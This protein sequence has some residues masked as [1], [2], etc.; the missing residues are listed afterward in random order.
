MRNFEEW[1]ILYVPRSE[2]LSVLQLC[3][4][5]KPLFP[6]IKILQL[7]DVT[8]EFIPFIPSFLSPRTTTIEINFIKKGLPKAVVASMVATLP[9]LC[10]NLRKICLPSLPRGPVITTAVSEMLLA[11]NRNTLQ[12][13]YVNCPL[14]EEAREVIFK[15][16]NLR[17]LSVVIEKGTSSP[18]AVL[19]NLTSLFVEYDHGNDWLQMFRGTRL[20]KLDTVFFHS[21]SEQT[22]DFLEAFKTVA[23]AAFAQNTLSELGF[24][25]SRSWNPNY[26]ALLPFTQLTCLVVHCPCNGGCS[27]SVDDDT[28]LNLART[29]PK[30]RFLRLGGTP[31]R[32]IPIGVTVKGLVALAHHCPDL[33]TLRVHFQVAS[34]SALPAMTSNAGSYALRMNCSLA[35]L[36]VGEIRVQEESVVTVALT[37]V[38]I[39]P[40]I[41]EIDHVDETWE[42]VV[43]TIHR[44]RLSRR[45]VDCSS[46]ERFLYASK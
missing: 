5:N 20:E 28:I 12:A 44:S 33:S 37:L 31:C 22:G 45:I 2:V 13:V 41:K 21:K 42:K 38:F 16:P 6:H 3:V 8:G 36:D 27:S 14:T 35:T 23:L 18:S 11:I 25:T 1:A 34:L 32:E 7:W 4:I 24:Y 43:D 30:L 46:K 26:S 17:E 19:P 40:H 29:M 9:T 10:P 39:L 15:L